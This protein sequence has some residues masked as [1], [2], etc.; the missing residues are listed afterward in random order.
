MQS[1]RI[2]SQ[3]SVFFYF[4]AGWKSFQE[5]GNIVPKLKERPRFPLLRNSVSK[6]ELVCYL[7]WGE[8]CVGCRELVM[9]VMQDK[10]KSQFAQMEADKKATG[11]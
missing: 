1:A 7:L 6:N 10:L 5:P 3:R 4:G 9:E 8:L 11:S 2:Y